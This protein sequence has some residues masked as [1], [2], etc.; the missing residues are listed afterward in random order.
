M[1]EF[2]WTGPCG[3]EALLGPWAETGHREWHSVY[4]MVIK[5]ITL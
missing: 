5:G 2:D 3:D 1:A 4:E